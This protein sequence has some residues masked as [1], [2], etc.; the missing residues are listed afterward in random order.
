MAKVGCIIFSDRVYGIVRN[1]YSLT[2]LIRKDHPD[3]FFRKLTAKNISVLSRVYTSKL[4]DLR[5]FA[6]G[7]D[8]TIAFIAVGLSECAGGYDYGMMSVHVNGMISELEE[9]G[10][11]VCLINGKVNNKLNGKF[12]IFYENHHCNLLKISKE[13]FCDIIRP[14]FKLLFLDKKDYLISSHTVLSYV[15]NICSY[16]E[17]NKHV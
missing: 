6:Q 11:E 7:N 12:S 15:N 17:A 13:R 14:E 16:I 3:I 1:R 4:E 8:K 5:K 10:C 2:E 9:I